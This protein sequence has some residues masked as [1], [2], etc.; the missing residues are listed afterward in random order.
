[1]ASQLSTLRTDGIVFFLP[2]LFQGLLL[3]SVATL[4]SFSGLLLVVIVVVVVVVGS[5]SFLC[6]RRRFFAGAAVIVVV[7]FFVVAIIAIVSARC[8]GRCDSSEERLE[9]RR[10]EHLP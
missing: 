7:V 5:L 2:G 6:D 3:R 10:A 1:R 9:V 4:A 8:V